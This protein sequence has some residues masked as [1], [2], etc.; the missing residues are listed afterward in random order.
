MEGLSGSKWGSTSV[1]LAAGI[2]EP[3]IGLIQNQPRE[4]TLIGHRNRWS[5]PPV[6]I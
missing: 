6:R 4:Q 3:I 5:F 2:V 1:L